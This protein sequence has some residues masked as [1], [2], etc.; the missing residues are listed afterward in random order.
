MSS[1]KRATKELTVK[2]GGLVTAKG[3]ANFGRFL[4]KYDILVNIITGLALRFI[5]LTS[6]LYKGIISLWAVGMP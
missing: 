4:T 3:S 5:S 2:D 1:D 6:K